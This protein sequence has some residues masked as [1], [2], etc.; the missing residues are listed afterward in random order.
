[1]YW[2]IALF[3]I[4][5]E[6]F[7]KS[8]WKELSDKSIS[9]YSKEVKDGVPHLTL[10]CYNKLNKSEFIRQIDTYYNNKA[11]I[12]ITF[13]TIGSFLNNGTLFLSPTITKELM[14][15]HVNH[16]NHFKVFNES[17][18]PL[19]LPGNWIPHCT[20]A[21][22]LPPERLSEAFSYCLKRYN[23]I[24]GKIKAVALL[25]LVDKNENYFE[26]PIIYLKELK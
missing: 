10:A 20:L 9:F 7:I 14:D 12:E 26:A 18:N 8:I 2:F 24:I 21:N 19:Y 6:K 16:H 22:K 25:E 1:M 17:A 13:N 15:F 23:P 4:N 5:I 11:G 3:D